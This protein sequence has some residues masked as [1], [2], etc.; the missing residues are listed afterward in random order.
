M[1]LTYLAALGHRSIV[2]IGCPRESDDCWSWE[3]E[4]RRDAYRR[5]MAAHGL[6]WTPEHEVPATNDLTAAQH[7]LRRLVASPARP[8]AAVVVNDWTAIV[9][10]KAALTSGI[11]VP[12][13]LSLVG[14]D[15]LAFSALC[16]PGLTTI[17]QPLDAMGQHAANALLDRIER[18]PPAHALTNP[19]E[20]GALHVIFTPTLIRRESCAP[21]SAAT[22]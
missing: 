13:D 17:R 21:P 7:V 2:F 6:P 1:G 3:S 5:F 4:Q 14:F 11:R 19:A 15:D 12:H 9:A 8:T 18:T 20:H 10:L 22:V 16:S